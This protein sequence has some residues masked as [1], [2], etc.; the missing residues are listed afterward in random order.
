ASSLER[1]GRR[2]RLLLPCAL[3]LCGRGPGLLWRWR[4]LLLLRR[5]LLI[6]LRRLHRTRLGFA[7]RLRLHRL[8]RCNGRCLL[9][10]LGGSR[11]SLRRRV[12]R[13]LIA[14]LIFRRDALADARH[15]FR[16]YRTPVAGQLLL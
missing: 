3:A 1:A 7:F 5:G 12:G 15:T 4:S 8:G 11:R 2:R 14:R 16:K 10:W 6:L 9:P 13:L